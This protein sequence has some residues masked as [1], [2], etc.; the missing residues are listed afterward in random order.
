LVDAG[1]LPDAV[2]RQPGPL[3]SLSQ[4]IAQR[5]SFRLLRHA[6]ILFDAWRSAKPCNLRAILDEVYPLSLAEVATIYETSLGLRRLVD[7]LRDLSLAEAG[8]LALHPRPVAVAP[9]LAHEV[10]LFAEVAAGQG[11]TLQAAPDAELPAVLADPQRLAQVLQ[12]AEAGWFS[13]RSWNYWQQKLGL[14]RSG[15]VP[16]LP[17]RHFGV[18]DGGDHAAA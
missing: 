2:P 5:L 12:R 7:D 14:A 13:P 10:A 8:R 16:P 4:F 18:R 11:V 1:L 17:R 9:L 15:A 3:D 6:C